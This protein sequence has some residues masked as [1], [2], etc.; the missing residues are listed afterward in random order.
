MDNA[1][2]HVFGENDVFINFLWEHFG[3]HVLMLPTGSPKFNPIELLWN[4]L[5]QHV[6]L[7]N[8]HPS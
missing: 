7:I 2:I 8:L 6:K 4:F 3:I 1:A 5:V